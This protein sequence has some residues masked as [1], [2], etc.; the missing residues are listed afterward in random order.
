MGR[1][2]PTGG[3]TADIV[4]VGSGTT[5]DFAGRDVRARIILA[6]G[7]ATPQVAAL[8]RDAGAVG[9]LHI[10]PHHHLHE[11]CISPVWG[12][13]D[14]TTFSQLPATVACTISHA[15]ANASPRAKRP[16]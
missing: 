14:P 15:S 5:A 8:A 13:P 16:A 10:S 7:I 1:P 6:D 9:Q 3:L 12:S 4:Y 2:S 11:M